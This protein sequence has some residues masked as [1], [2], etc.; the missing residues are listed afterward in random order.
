MTENFRGGAIFFDSHC[1]VYLPWFDLLTSYCARP[2]SCFWTI[3][4]LDLGRGLHAIKYQSCYT[5]VSVT[6]YNRALQV[7]NQMEVVPLGEFWLFLPAQ[8]LFSYFTV[9]LPGSSAYIVRKCQTSC[10]SHWC[11]LFPKFHVSWLLW[12]EMCVAWLINCHL[13]SLWHSSSSVVINNPFI[14]K[15]TKC[16]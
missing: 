14:H 1:T 15:L 6:H 9:G 8:P 16:S 2:P 11:L 3:R 10:S 4:A 12:W 5:P 13:F 7:C